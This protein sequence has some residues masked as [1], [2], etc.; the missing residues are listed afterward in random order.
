MKILHLIYDHMQ[1]PWVGGGGAVRAHE[2]CRRL[3]SAGHDVTVLS[4]RYPG[5]KGYRDGNL[6]CEFVGS[7]AGYVLSTFSYA[8]R[9]AEFVRKEGS[10]FD[11]IVEDFAPWNPVFSILFTSRPVVL[12]VNHREGRGILKRLWIFG[13]PF[14]MVERWYPRLFKRITALSEETKRKIDIPRAFI[15]PAG[16]DSGIIFENAAERIDEKDNAFIL[17]VGR[18]HIRNKGLDVL[19]S[20]MQGIDR[21]LVLAGKGKD[22]KRLKSMAER[23]GPDGI[24]FLGF[25]TE[26]EKTSLLKEDCILV[27]PSRFEGWGIVVLEAAACGKPVVVSDIPELRYAVDAG[28]GI[29]FRIGDAKDLAEKLQILLNNRSM[30]RDMGEKGIDYAKRFT[31]DRIAKEYER[32]LLQVASRIDINI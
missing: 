29:S 5:A 16:I 18:L 8:F 3:A 7:S 6:S 4:G 22:E 14:Y 32:Y 28:F 30:R 17:Y 27:L 24:E 1:N 11:V 26:E 15:L 19:L 13:L 20:S 12:H 23:Q 21:R 31:W 10:R 25:V 9:A 2:I